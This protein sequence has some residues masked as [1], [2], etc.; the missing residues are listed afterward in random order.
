MRIGIFDP[1]LDTLGG[2]EK[3]MLTA[4]SFLSKE[5]DVSVFWDKDILSE[6]SERF[7]LDLSKVKLKRNIFD[8][9]VSLA[10][11]LIETNKYD[12][13]FYL[14]DGS[15]PITASSLY[16][17]FQFPVEWVN[18]KS[19]ITKQKIRRVKKFICNSNFTKEFIDKKF[20]VRS[21]VLYPPTYLTKEFPKPNLSSKKNH[22]LN[23][24]RLTKNESGEYF[25]KQDVLIDAF[26]K[27]SKKIDKTWEL[28]LAVSFIEKD[29]ELLNEL[30]KMVK[31]Y[32][33]KIY[34]N[35]SFEKLTRLYQESKIYW[36]ASGFG[37][38]LEKN[39][40]KAE[41]FGITTV[42][43]MTNGLV[44]VVINAGGQKEIVDNKKNGFVWN[45]EEELVKYTLNLID[46][47]L[48]LTKLS[49]AAIEK[50]HVFSADEFN[51][52]LIEI[53]KNE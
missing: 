5:N 48:L 1:Y 47:S 44:P 35:L 36:H 45:S 51:K 11:K 25:K 14:S 50:S 4:A 33:I 17:H 34:N 10:Q 52:R 9:K 42:E 41:H 12:A 37:E 24:G 40:E 7:N 49:N 6:A 13:I 26:K 31:G 29:K 18:G 53:F 38:D 21:I 43:A 16:I 15:I 8:R 2:G 30:N 46:D 27:L 20:N 32:P 22:I 28:V 19:L 39:P 3:Y 23:V